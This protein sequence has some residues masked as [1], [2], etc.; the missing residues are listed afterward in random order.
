MSENNQTQNERPAAGEQKE[1]GS[2]KNGHGHRNNRHRSHHRGNRSHNNKEKTPREE[3]QAMNAEQTDA[4][5]RP[6]KSHNKDHREKHGGDRRE[7]QNG[8]GREKQ[9]G[10]G[11]EK[12]NGEGRS[13]AQ[14]N[15]DRGGKGNHR[16]HGRYSNEKR[17]YDPYEAPN[18][19][20]I[21]FSKLRAQ[22]VIKSADGTVPTVYGEA[23]TVYPT[24]PAV[25]PVAEPA[26]EET[27][28]PR[29]QEP[30]SLEE[31][32]EAATPEAPAEEAKKVEVVGVRF[33]SAGKMYYFDP[34]GITAKKGE[35]A[36]VET[37]RG[38][39][40]GEICLANT[41]ISESNTVSP[42]RPLIRIAS[43]A[44]V[45]HN[46]AN[47]AAEKEA[48]AICQKKVAEHGLG[49][50]LI[51]VQYAFDNSKLLFYFSAEGRVDFRELVKDL[52]SVFR[53]RIEL[54]QI[55]I[56]DEAKMLGGI[57]ACGRALCCSTFLPDFAQVS[58]KMAKEQNLSLNS[59]KISGV[60]GRLMCC[61]RYESEVYSEEI[62]KTPANDTLVKTEDGIGTVISSNPLAGTVRVILKDSPDTPPKQYHR[63][64]I[65]VLPKEQKHA[66]DR[67]PHDKNAEKEEN[68]G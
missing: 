37:T 36:I 33:R 7:K 60:C 66:H 28:E 32:T 5:A 48:L 18:K 21:E 27:A 20:E 63:D 31:G 51:D 35:F 40:F 11:R 56:R 26:A 52:A 24:A 38:P 58:I 23:P 6:Q 29:A 1:N 10:E 17:P 34:H 19:E 9:N 39:E 22:I 41:M 43:P 57:G 42:L 30:T 50:K 54:R 4:Q 45:E 44:D 46:E 13:R 67:R 64:S 49:M 12:Q 8:E 16:S 65:T 15:F 61:L 68:N 25:E 3:L 47:R 14:K 59:S 62:K 53:T 2:Q 55:G